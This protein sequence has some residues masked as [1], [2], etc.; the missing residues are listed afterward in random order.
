MH[1]NLAAQR[2]A[3]YLCFLFY[4]FG[5]SGVMNFPLNKI[6]WLNLKNNEVM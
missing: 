6:I 3:T 2:Q 1:F 5:V 4:F